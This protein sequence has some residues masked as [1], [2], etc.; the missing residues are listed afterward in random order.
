[1]TYPVDNYSV[2]FATTI[3]SRSGTYI[4]RVASLHPHDGYLPSNQYINDIGVAKM[5]EAMKNPLYDYLVRLPVAGAFYRTGLP[6][7]LIG[8]GW[9][10]TDGVTMTH[11]QKVDLQVVES[12]DCDKIHN[13]TVHFS[14]I[15][16]GVPEGG[17][18]Q[19]SGDSGGP[20]LV[21]GI[22]VGVVSWSVK[23]CGVALY[24]GKIEFDADLRSF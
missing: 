10:Q 1:M 7:T 23:P 22:Q 2:Q 5:R 15:C 20:L 18:G 14:N 3:I 4:V 9:N 16:A 19:C 21:D 24:P 12:R 11:L 13:S 6:A 8:W 17:R